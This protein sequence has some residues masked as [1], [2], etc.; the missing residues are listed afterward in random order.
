MQVLEL[1][2]TPPIIRV[3]AYKM[4]QPRVIIPFLNRSFSLPPG[5][6]LYLEDNAYVETLDP[7]DVVLLLAKREE[8][9]P[10]LRR[11]LV[12]LYM[13]PPTSLLT[14]LANQYATRAKFLFNMFRDRDA[15]IAPFAVHISGTRRAHVKAVV[16]LESVFDAHRLKDLRYKARHGSTRKSIGDLYKVINAACNKHP[17][18]QL[19]L[20]KFNSALTRHD[21]QDRIV[22][23]SICLESLIDG[24]A[25]VAFKCSLYNALT[26]ESDYALREE[27]FRLLSDVY[28]ARSKIVHGETID[29]DKKPFKS[30][31]S[32]WDRVLDLAANAVMYYVLYMSVA[33][34]DRQKWSTH[35]KRL[36]MGCDHLITQPAN[37][38]S[39]P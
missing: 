30:V 31:Y 14:E 25:E 33:D 12:A 15:V 7:E 13:P 2:L 17:G 19:T 1:S 28:S 32:E 8:Y 22:D 34:N 9:A 35:Q 36:A 23:I 39:T 37:D 27:T 16:E 20:N 38:Q 29:A 4:I 18:V 11:R 26:S 10:F 21:M 5:P 6:R 24:Q 3:E